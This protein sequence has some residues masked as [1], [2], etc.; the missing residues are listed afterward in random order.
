MDK[1]SKLVSG[2]M[3]QLLIE[4][5][6]PMELADLPTDQLA[7]AIIAGFQVN[8]GVVGLITNFNCKLLQQIPPKSQGQ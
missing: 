1:P 8:L 5:Q 2:K 4:G 7:A 3:F 6:V